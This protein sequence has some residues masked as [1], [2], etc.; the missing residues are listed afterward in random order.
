MIDGNTLKQLLRL[1][2][3]ELFEIC[4]TLK[5]GATLRQRLL[6]SPLPSLSATLVCHF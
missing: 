4:E 5:I 2:D 3:D 6:E 1:D